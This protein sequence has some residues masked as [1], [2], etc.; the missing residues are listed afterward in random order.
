MGVGFT[1]V[2]QRKTNYLA[3]V[4]L[5]KGGAKPKWLCLICWLFVRP[6]SFRLVEL[7]CWSRWWYPRSPHK[8][9]SGSTAKVLCYM[10]RQQ[11]H[12]FSV[13]RMYFAYSNLDTFC[14]R[15]SK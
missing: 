4:L 1:L 12:D 13:R 15:S 14:I 6:L 9:A 7:S 2:L 10:Q 3:R 5:Q 11:L 8:M